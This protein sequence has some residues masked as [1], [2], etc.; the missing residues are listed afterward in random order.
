MGCKG[1]DMFI[2]HHMGVHK[3]PLN[4]DDLALKS[5]NKMH[6]GYHMQV[7]WDIRDQK[8]IGGNK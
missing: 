1:K 3:I 2:M 4:M 5:Y 7:E 8:E 6:V